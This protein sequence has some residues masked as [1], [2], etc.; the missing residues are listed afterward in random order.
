[1][2]QTSIVA[3]APNVSTVS[4]AAVAAI[5]PGRPLLVA[6]S[7]RDPGKNVDGT[8][9]N[10]MKFGDYSKDQICKI[11]WNF[12][13][14]DWTAGLDKI[15]AARLFAAFRRMATELF[16]MSSLEAN[17]ERMID[18]FER[19]EGG[20]YSD[21]A[22][23]RAAR[24]HPRTYAFMKE[25]EGKLHAAIARH[26]GDANKIRYDNDIS[27]AARI[28][29]NEWG[30]ILGGLTIATNDI[31]AWR[32]EIIEYRLTSADYVGKYKITLFDHFGLDEPDVDPSKRYGNL[33]GFRAWFILQHLQRFAYQPFL[34]VIEIEEPFCGSLHC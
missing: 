34:T 26:S 11:R 33:A 3:N 6:K 1:M 4:N 20:S 30:D 8:V 21:P 2:Q 5:T 16:A 7:R 14:D 25:F 22:L 29:F 13:V 15:S 31:W 28:L 12:T 9:A 17:I 32:V 23:T 10:D 18:K 19:N 24:A 27:M